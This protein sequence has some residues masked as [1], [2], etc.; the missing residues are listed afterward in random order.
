MSFY[1]TS[2]IKTKLGYFSLTT[3]NNYIISYYPSNT[4]IIKVNSNIIH[5]I[6]L[7]K[8]EMYLIKKTALL[9]FKVKQDGTLFQ[10][11]VWKEINKIRYGKTKTYLDIAKNLNSSPR[12][13]GRACAQNGCLIIIPCHRVIHSDGEIGDYVLGKK[14]K[15]YLN[16]LKQKKI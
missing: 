9:N 8:I 12:A 7:K 6:F 4:N 13:V 3:V 1:N 16:K 15:E 2:I 10:Q 14:T 11:S 5:K